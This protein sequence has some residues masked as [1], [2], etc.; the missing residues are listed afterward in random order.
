LSTGKYKAI[1]ISYYSSI[2]RTCWA[3]LERFRLFCTSRSWPL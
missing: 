1:I 3:D 2:W